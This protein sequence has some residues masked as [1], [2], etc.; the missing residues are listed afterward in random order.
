MEK[1]QYLCSVIKEQ[2]INNNNSINNYEKGNFLNCNG[3]GFQ[4]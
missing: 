4:P 3:N 1:K 2:T